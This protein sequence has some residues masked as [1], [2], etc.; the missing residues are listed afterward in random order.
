MTATY[1][2]RVVSIQGKKV[3]LI[4]TPSGAH[5]DI[6][7]PDFTKEFFLAILWEGTEARR[8]RELLSRDDHTLTDDSKYVLTTEISE[9]NYYSLMKTDDPTP[10]FHVDNYIQN[11]D[12]LQNGKERLLSILEARVQEEGVSSLR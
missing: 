2:M 5:L 6:V 7:N 11:I 12:H 1:F 3:V 8:Y 9:S 10:D 4:I